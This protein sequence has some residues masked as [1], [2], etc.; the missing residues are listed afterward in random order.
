VQDTSPG[1]TRRPM[2]KGHE[3]ELSPIL[4]E[5]IGWVAAEPAHSGQSLLETWCQRDLLRVRFL[6]K[7][8]TIEFYSVAW[9]PC[10]R[11]AMASAVGGA[12][13]KLFNICMPG[14][15]AS[16]L[17]CWACRPPWCR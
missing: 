5:F 15:T 2:I 9:R 17:T 8:A 11:F 13:E 3:A 14:V 1:T 12:M 6:S 10:Q 7:C 4:R 16:G